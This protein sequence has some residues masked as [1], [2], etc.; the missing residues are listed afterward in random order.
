MSSFKQFFT[1]RGCEH[2]FEETPKH[3]F[4]VLGPPNTPPTPREKQSIFEEKATLCW[5]FDTKTSTEVLIFPNKEWCCEH[6]FQVN[7]ITFSKF[8]VLY[9]LKSP[10]FYRKVTKKAKFYRVLRSK[11]IWIHTSKKLR[12]QVRIRNQNPGQSGPDPG[13]N[14]DSGKKGPD[15][16]PCFIYLLNF[17]AFIHLT[18][19]VRAEQKWL[20]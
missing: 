16:D 7:E 19:K 12:I 8:L 14:Q 4:D 11:G 10:N 3:Q 9:R 20:Q 13:P 15:L 6:I 17:V 5:Q 2:F 18:K 1:L